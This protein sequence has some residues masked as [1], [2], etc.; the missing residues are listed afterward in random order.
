MAMKPMNGEIS[1][2]NGD[3]GGL[4]PHSRRYIQN[5]SHPHATGCAG[6]QRDE[7][8]AAKNVTT[9]LRNCSGFWMCGMWPQSGTS[10]RVEPLMAACV[11]RP[12]SG[13][14]PATHC[15]LGGKRFLP[16][17]VRSACPMISSVG[18]LI[19]AIS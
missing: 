18:R 9:A 2:I 1:L 13:Y 19:S 15:K 14:C 17:T 11:L 6:H 10:T 16:T 7:G 3:G 8:A 5:H 12:S 4:L